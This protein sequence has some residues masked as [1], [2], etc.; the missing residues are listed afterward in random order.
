MNRN[1]RIDRPEGI[2]GQ[3]AGRMQPYSSLRRFSAV[4]IH[5][6][7]SPAAA[8][9]TPQKFEPARGRWSAA[10]GACTHL[11]IIMRSLHDADTETVERTH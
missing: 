6:P 1:R 9:D 11:A 3:V 4:P 10:R 5:G 7:P 2:D 8:R